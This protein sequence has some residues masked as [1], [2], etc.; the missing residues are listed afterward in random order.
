[1]AII[2]LT[3][4]L[5]HRDFYQSA[6][7]GAILSSLPGANIVDISHQIMPFNVAQAAYVV[8]N[9]YRF[10]PPGTIHVLGVDAFY[11]P[12]PR[13]LA[14]LHDGHYFIGPDNGIFSLMFEGSPE[15][16]IGISFSPDPA[17]THFPLLDILVKAA[18][19]LAGGGQAEELG[20]VVTDMTQRSVL[21]PVH[22]PGLIRGSV[23][24]IDSFQNVVTNITRE[25]FDSVGRNQ[26]F[27]LLFSRNESI[28]TI[29]RYYQEVPEGEKLCL[30]GISGHLEIAINKGNAAGLLGLNLNDI[31]IIQFE[32]PG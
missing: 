17:Y 9:A 30:F 18:V 7:K 23:I 16:A 10:F 24:H 1:M 6:V 19:H 21:Q 27:E 8:R 26:P 11:Q 13:Y 3:T 22:E 28:T 31:V 2:T 12:R 20:S 4:D 14:V 29:S 32:E 5:G 15:K 25:L